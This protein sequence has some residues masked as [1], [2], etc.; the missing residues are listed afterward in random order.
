MDFTITTVVSGQEVCLHLHGGVDLTGTGLVRDEVLAVLQAEQ[1]RQV[2]L[3]LAE[4]NSFDPAGM[5][6]LVA[7]QRA[8]HVRGGT[9]RL[10]N[11]PPFVRRHLFAAGLLGLLTATPD[12]EAT[13][14][15]LAA[16]TP[17]MREGPPP[18]TTGRQPTMD[19]TR[20]NEG[21]RGPA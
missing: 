6:A 17:R 9:L 19:I 2:Q 15:T 5:G 4:V 7:C 8:V 3:D 12:E 20:A 11:I 16:P 18:A 13:T 1:V 21:D 10:V 14:T